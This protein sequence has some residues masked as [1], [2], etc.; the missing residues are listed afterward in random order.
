[1]T[2]ADSSRKDLVLAVNGCEERLQVALGRTEQD[3]VHLLASREWT[4]PGQSVRYLVPG[5]SEMLADF[6]AAMNRV[7]R[8]ACTRGPGSFTGLR[9]ALAA[10]QGLAAGQSV[11]LAG[12]D[13]MPLLAKAPAPLLNGTLHVLTYARRNHVY[14]QSFSCPNAASLGPATALKTDAALTLLETDSGPASALGSGLAKHPDFRD[15]LA[16]KGIRILL[17]HWDAPTPEILLEAAMSADFSNTPID[18][19]YIRVSDAE[20]NL[21]FIAKKRGI[22]PEEAQRR[23]DEY[24]K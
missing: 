19:L 1:M 6:G 2:S 18:P 3:G 8:M 23:L 14:L 5:I 21:P 13:Y 4:V 22:D 11:P 20:E 24:R 17:P 10:V 9:L 7:A 16:D 15:A 12:L